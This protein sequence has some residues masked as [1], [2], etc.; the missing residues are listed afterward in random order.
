MSSLDPE[1]KTTAFFFP[2]VFPRKKHRLIF[3]SILY[4][5]IVSSQNIKQIKILLID[6]KND[7]RYLV[8]FPGEKLS[9]FWLKQLK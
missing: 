4:F 5:C 9:A 8:L 7:L 2:D 1:Y 6:K 3:G